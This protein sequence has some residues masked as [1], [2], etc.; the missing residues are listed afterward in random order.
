MACVGYPDA[1]SRA[2]TVDAVMKG[3]KELYESTEAMISK[4]GEGGNMRT[5]VAERVRPE[6]SLSS[7]LL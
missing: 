3:R 5:R 2:V 4:S 6:L 1:G 7:L